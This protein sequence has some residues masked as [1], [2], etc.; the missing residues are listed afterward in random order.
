MIQK[1]IG[2][3]VRIEEAEQSVPGILRLVKIDECPDKPLYFVGYGKGVVAF[4]DR[5]VDGV[6]ARDDV[7]VIAVTGAIWAT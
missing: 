4:G 1:L 7:P 6:I 2:K 5:N 3:H